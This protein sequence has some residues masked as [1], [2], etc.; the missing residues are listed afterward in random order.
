MSLDNILGSIT[1]GSSITVG[2]VLICT[3]ASL[4]LGICVAFI[5]MRQSSYTK[6]FVVTLALLPAMVQIVI[7]LV[8]GNLG[9]GVAVMGTFSLVRFRSAAGT[10]R[11]IGSIFFAMALGL[12]MGMG[13]LAFAVLFLLL[14]GGS[15]LLLQRTRFGEP[16]EFERE[17]KIV[18]PENMD[19][20]GIF[21]DLL[22]TYTKGAELIRVRTTNMG[23]LYELTYR[24]QLKGNIVQKQFLDQL[25]CRNGNLN[26]TCGRPTVG[27]AEL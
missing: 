25:R 4:L 24:I 2:S 18:I 14:I 5:Y 7:M 15:M 27:P 19:Y 10:A 22:S 26:I 11:E 6:S 17:L 12:A 3:I 20:E 8:N 1:N 16:S 9:A 21:D 13:Y 23:S